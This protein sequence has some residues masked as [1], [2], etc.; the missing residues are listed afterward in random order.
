[1]G[2]KKSPKASPAAAAGTPQMPTPAAVALEGAEDPTRQQRTHLLDAEADKEQSASGATAP[3][4][5]RAEL[6]P[7]SVIVAD[8]APLDD[9]TDSVAV[10]APAD[11][12]LPPL[13]A[14]RSRLSR[15]T[16]EH[17]M[18][19]TRTLD[20]A[21]ALHT[22]GVDQK[23]ALRDD[24]VESVCAQLREAIALREKYRSD[25]DRELFHGEEA[26][27]PVSDED[28]PDP[29]VP[30]PSFRGGHYSFEMRRGVMLVW[31]EAG[32]DRS[33]QRPPG[34]RMPA[35]AP[36]FVAPPTFAEFTDDLSRLMEITSSAAVNS[37]CYRRLQ[38]LDA[39]FKLH[40]MEHEQE[41]SKEQRECVICL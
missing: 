17:A 12:S 6:R 33:G 22:I 18:N 9:R 34:A 29:F 39:R 26:V 27:P 14:R 28:M 11:P 19:E 5:S 13:T 31:S 8:G 23:R 2:K 36:C 21:G 35:S 20:Q 1:M 32:S 41:E 7:P 3:A 24:E 10:D 40:V 25:H 16:S 4:P 38:R 30:T 37:F 15:M